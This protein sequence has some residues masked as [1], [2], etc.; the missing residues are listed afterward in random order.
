MNLPFA[1]WLASWSSDEVWVQFH[2]VAYSFAWRQRPQRNVLA[3]AE[4]LMA[5]LIAGR[6]DRVFVSIPA[7]RRQLGRHAQRAEVLS[8]PSNVPVDVK[9]EDVERVVARLGPGPLVGHFG[10]YGTWVAG[11][12]RPVVR[13]ILQSARDARLVLLGIGGLDFARNLVTTYP[14]LAARII[15]PGALAA[16]DVSCHLAAC[17]VLV[18]PYPDG[19]S[20]RRTSAMAGLALG[21]PIVTT[22]GHLTEDHWAS[23]GAVV[24][25]PVGEP[26]DL[27]SAV[28][29]LLAYPERREALGAR[30]RAWYEER[31]SIS[32]S[33]D[34][35]GSRDDSVKV[36]LC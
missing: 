25:V 20:G 24:L 34:L 31:L 26:H 12:L 19:I 30:A 15:A 35:L 9:P 1:L 5:Q 32:H 2:E 33:L 16:A 17:D 23:S 14:D 6:A 7:W 27:A 13:T 36:T 21:K 8:I 28:L 29:G 22:T 10:T 18:Q 3:A 11:L 4:W